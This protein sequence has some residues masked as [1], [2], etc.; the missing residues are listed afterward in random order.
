MDED[1]LTVRIAAYAI[2]IGSEAGDG[3]V[4]VEIGVIDKELAIILI[5]RMEGEAEES[6]LAAR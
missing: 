1:F 4:A 3:F 6:L 5:V 2:S